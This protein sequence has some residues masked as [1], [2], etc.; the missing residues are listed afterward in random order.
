[1]QYRQS[2]SVYYEGVHN[3][4][5]TWLKV[6]ERLTGDQN[7]EETCDSPSS[8]TSH[9]SF[10]NVTTGAV[11]MMKQEE[12]SSSTDQERST[13]T[14]PR[15]SLI[16]AAFD[17]SIQKHYEDAILKLKKAVEAGEV[18]DIDD[19]SL[20]DNVYSC[21][22]SKID[23]TS[24]KIKVCE[25]WLGIL[26][27]VSQTT[28]G[29]WLAHYQLSLYYCYHLIGAILD[30]S[31]AVERHRFF[32]Q[33]QSTFRNL[34]E[35]CTTTS[36]VFEDSVGAKLD[37]LLSLSYLCLQ[38]ND[39]ASR[40]HMAFVENETSSTEMAVNQRFPIEVASHLLRKVVLISRNLEQCES[41]QFRTSDVKTLKTEPQP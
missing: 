36:E 13:A 2:E 4:N 21:K 41:L 32:S 31:E 27:K 19:I 15:H 35:L 14:I 6:R 16:N 5:P 10:D 26:T 22:M 1:M 7:I 28:N 20:I 34:L 12:L 29:S 37:I 17:D 3:A 30:H 25:E 23:S 38:F 9:S 8:S 33:S 39:V 24:K 18:F 40:E 11:N